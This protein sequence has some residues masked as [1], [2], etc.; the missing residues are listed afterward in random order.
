MANI[1]A[2]LSRV[3]YMDI[4]AKLRKLSKCYLM[5]NIASESCLVYFYYVVFDK[6]DKS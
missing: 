4:V 3:L 2:G 6:K 1:W 5:I